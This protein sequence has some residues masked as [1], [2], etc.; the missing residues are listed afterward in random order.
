MVDELAIQ[1]VTV[2]MRAVGKAR[3]RVTANGTYMPLAYVTAKQELRARFGPVTVGMPAAIE[4]VA[5]RKAPGSL[6]QA[7]RT[8]MVGRPC[9]IRPDADNILGWVMDALFGDDSAVADVSCRKIWG[10]EDEV[11]ITI[12]AITGE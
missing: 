5:V 10:L 7:R 8:A 1:Q 2:P 9:T 6:S 3:P 11:R 4:V 12:R